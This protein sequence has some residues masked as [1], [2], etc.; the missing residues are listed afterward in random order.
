MFAEENWNNADESWMARLQ[1]F[2]FAHAK[3]LDLLLFTEPKRMQKVCLKVIISS[4]QCDFSFDGKSVGDEPAAI[5]KHFGTSL[6]VFDGSPFAL[7]GSTWLARN[8]EVEHVKGSWRSLG[9]FP[10]VSKHI[11]GFSTVT[12]KNV[13]YIFGMSNWFSPCFS[14]FYFILFH[15]ININLRIFC[16]NSGGYGDGSYMDLAAKY[17][18]QWLRAG[19]LMQPRYGHRSLLQGSKIIHVGGYP[20]E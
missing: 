12:V 11:Y 16:R 14:P 3:S 5:S 6:G 10:F 17:D 7:G 19:S 8:K 18:G 15:S 1:F 13:L 9:H 4:S 2:Q 20:G